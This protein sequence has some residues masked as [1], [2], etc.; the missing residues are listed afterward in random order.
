MTYNIARLSPMKTALKLAMAN[1]NG[2]LM[3]LCSMALRNSHII[4]SQFVMHD[5]MRILVDEAHLGNVVYDSL[6][7]VS[8]AIETVLQDNVKI[9]ISFS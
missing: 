9:F 2:A 5:V 4:N 8:I 6:M 7:N 1:E 3:K